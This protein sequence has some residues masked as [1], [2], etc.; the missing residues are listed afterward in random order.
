MVASVQLNRNN[1][2]T[3]SVF[4]HLQ[5]LPQPIR[6]LEWVLLTNKLPTLV[7]CDPGDECLIGHCSV[8]SPYKS[9]LSGPHKPAQVITRRRKNTTS[10]HLLF[11]MV[12]CIVSFP[13]RVM[14][15]NALKGALILVFDSDHK[16]IWVVA[17]SNAQTKPIREKQPEECC[18]SRP[19]VFQTKFDPDTLWD[20]YQLDAKASRELLRLRLRLRVSN[21][22]RAG[23]KLCCSL[24]YKCHPPGQH[25]P[26][27]V[28]SY[29][30]RS[31][32]IFYA[33]CKNICSYI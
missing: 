12:M 13:M 8:S 19:G 24:P 16:R 26:S 6:R 22:V 9:H 15:R 14:E 23:A 18:E 11:N 1:T 4:R 32:E 30:S 2:L 3:H 33:L 17:L 31:A 28:T 5:C 29:Y 10:L 7:C 27:H 20:N 25:G 21:N